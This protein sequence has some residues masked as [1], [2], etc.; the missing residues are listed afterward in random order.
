M[1]LPGWGQMY[2]GKPLKA[3]VVVAGEGFLVYKALDEFSKEN[4]A[5]DRLSQLAPGDPGYEQAVDDKEMHYNLKVNYI[6]WAVAVHLLQMADAYVD[7]QL[8]DFNADLGPLPGPGLGT[9]A[10]AGPDPGLSVALRARF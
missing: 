9:A 6:W 3:A 5:V 7:A 8:R 2:N 4:D 10:A 1:V